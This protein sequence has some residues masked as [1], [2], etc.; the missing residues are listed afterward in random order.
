MMRG[1]S[2]ETWWV[3]I[4]KYSDS[5][6]KQGCLTIWE[7]SIH[8]ID[9]FEIIWVSFWL[10]RGAYLF[11]SSLV[12]CNPWLFFLALMWV[13]LACCRFCQNYLSVFLLFQLA[14]SPNTHIHLRNKGVS[15]ISNL[16]YRCQ[17][18]IL[19]DG[20]SDKK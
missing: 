8:F 19:Y 3:V 14:T 11:C 4:S 17:S 2:S 16:K 1:G 5:D 10:P 13:L 9:I 7:D 6:Q 20:P 15:K 12:D 18:Q